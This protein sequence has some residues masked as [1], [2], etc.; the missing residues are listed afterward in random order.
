MPALESANRPNADEFALQ[1]FEKL[2][3]AANFVRKFT[4]GN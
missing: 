2:Q 3:Q 4:V 1:A